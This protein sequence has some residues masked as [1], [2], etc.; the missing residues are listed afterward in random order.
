MYDNLG[1]EH[2]RCA[3]LADTNDLSI[4]GDVLA[5]DV[6]ALKVFKDLPLR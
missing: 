2:D 3:C 1:S 6:L 5:G 4:A